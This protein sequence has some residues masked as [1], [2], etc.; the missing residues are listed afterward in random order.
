M[1]GEMLRWR[2][3]LFCLSLIPAT[4]SFILAILLFTP[5]RVIFTPV[6]PPHAATILTGIQDFF[7]GQRQGRD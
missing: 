7:N 1:G 5:A 2:A 6:A 4:M 3:A